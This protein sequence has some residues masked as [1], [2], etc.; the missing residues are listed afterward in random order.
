[1]GIALWDR[2]MTSRADQE[3][4]ELQRESEGRECGRIC[5]CSPGDTVTIAGTVRSITFR[6]RTELPSL[7]I[8]LYDGT[9]CIRVI[10]LGRR[11]ILGISAGRRL[12]VTGRLNQVAGE[13][14]VYNP[15]YEL[16]PMV[17]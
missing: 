15:R 14:V 17:A 8:D 13:P 5:D 9:G 4:S 16:K 12:V 2:L 1:V 10:W 3:A 6:P 7:E 11:R